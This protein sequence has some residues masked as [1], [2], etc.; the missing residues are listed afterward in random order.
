MEQL[1]VCESASCVKTLEM[2]CRSKN[3]STTYFSFIMPSRAPRL[4]AVMI[5]HLRDKGLDNRLVIQ[6][7]FLGRSQERSSKS[8]LSFN[9]HSPYNKN[10]L[11]L[12]PI[13][14]TISKLF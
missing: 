1:G 7:C 4:E 10:A 12:L 14:H 9:L 3:T 5:S 8:L 11:Q 13:I 2:C 6:A